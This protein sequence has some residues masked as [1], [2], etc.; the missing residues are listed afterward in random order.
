MNQYGIISFMT[1]QIVDTQVLLSVIVN[2]DLFLFHR[3][4]D[5]FSLKLDN[6]AW[7]ILLIG[8]FYI[9]IYVAH[10]ENNGK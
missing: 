2:I 9:V 8:C 4:Y 6:L 3:R 7:S 1:P 10:S 5:A